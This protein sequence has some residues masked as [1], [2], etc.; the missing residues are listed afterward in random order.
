[1]KL[2]EVVPLPLLIAALVAVVN[3]MTEV[4]KKLLPVKNAPGVVT[5]WACL[6]TGGAAIAAA[7]MQGWTG[8][9]AVTLA[10]IVG[11]LIGGL[12]AYA[13]MLGYDELYRDVVTV[14]Q[15]LLDYRGQRKEETGEN[16]P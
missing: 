15:Q 14:L 12:I 6:L 13:A 10:C 9:G 4:T 2:F 7:V 8:F 16:K 11:L 1:M 5:L 3:V